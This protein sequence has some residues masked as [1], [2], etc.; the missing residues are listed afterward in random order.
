MEG[1]QLGKN[2]EDFTAVYIENEGMEV[3]ARNYHSRYGEVDI[4][5]LDGDTYAFVEVKTRTGTAYG[6]AG[7][8]VGFSKRK[9]LLMT[10]CCYI[11]QEQLDGFN[12]RFDVA[13]VYVKNDGMHMDYIKNAFEV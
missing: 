8:A 5:A 3:V 4:I 7:E 9:K 11:E 10:A 12:F 1:K 13:Q 2:G 6:T